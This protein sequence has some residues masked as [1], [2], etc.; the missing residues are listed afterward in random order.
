MRHIAFF[1]FD[2]TITTKDSLI[3]FIRFA[4]GDLKFLWGMF[5]LS[6]M[7]ILYKLRLIPNDQAKQ[8]MLSY[9]FKNM[10]KADFIHLANEYSLKRIKHILRPKAMERIAWHKQRKHEIVIVSAS[11]ESWLK[12]WCD[13]HSLAL[14]ATKLEFKH[15][16]IT[17]K[18]ATK[19]CY[20]IE[21]VTRIKNL[22]N[23]NNYQYIYAYGDSLG[24]KDLLALSDEKF[25]QPFR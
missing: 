15:N 21:K 1:D 3:D 18:F 2:G 7:L 16:T 20:G 10:V 11:I 6:P 25:Y 22:Y 8:K 13:D 23:L 9:F 17:G 5:F 12:P 4:I 19:N 14:I 24:D